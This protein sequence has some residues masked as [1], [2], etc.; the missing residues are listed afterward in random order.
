M[1]GEYGRLNHYRISQLAWDGERQQKRK[2]S[3][4]RVRQIALLSAQG[5]KVHRIALTTGASNLTVQKWQ[6]KLELA[7]EEDCERQLGEIFE[8]AW[9]DLCEGVVESKAQAMF[10]LLQKC[11]ED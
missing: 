6:A 9:C 5:V 11:L 8:T 7:Y 1:T 10:H 3:L 4:D 2:L